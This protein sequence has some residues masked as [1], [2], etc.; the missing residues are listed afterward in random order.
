MKTRTPTIHGKPYQNQ[1]TRA[2]YHNTRSVQYDECNQLHGFL[3][4]YATTYLLTPQFLRT[5]VAGDDL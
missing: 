2:N 5:I 4:I 1:D 3:H